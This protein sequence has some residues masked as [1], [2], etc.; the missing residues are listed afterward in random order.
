MFKRSEERRRRAA[1]RVLSLL[2]VCVTGIFSNNMEGS[3]CK[4][5]ADFFQ[6]FHA[7]TVY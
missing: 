5:L 2:L 6:V 3:M 7:P 1:R 4:Y